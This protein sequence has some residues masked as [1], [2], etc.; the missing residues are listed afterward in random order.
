MKKYPRRKPRPS[1]N[2]KEI[3]EGPIKMCPESRKM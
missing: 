1:H 3:L 2:I